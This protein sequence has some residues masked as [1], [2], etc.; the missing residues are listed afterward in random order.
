[1]RSKLI[2][3]L[4]IGSLIICGGRIFASHQYE[5]AKF[6]DIKVQIDKIVRQHHYV[7]QDVLLCFD[8]DCTL[9]TPNHYLGSVPWMNWQV[10]LL[11]KVTNTHIPR[12]LVAPDWDTLLLDWIVL[13]QLYHAPS[14]HATE[15]DIKS[16]LEDYTGQGYKTLILTARGPEFRYITE[17]QLKS[18]GLLG[19][20]EKHSFAF[21]NDGKHYLPY[22]TSDPEKY[23]LSTAEIKRFKLPKSPQYVSFSH[24]IM[25]IDGQNKGAILQTLVK[26]A[27][28]KYKYKCIVF[29]DDSSDNCSNVYNAFTEFTNVDVETFHYTYDDAWK[30]KFDDAQK[31]KCAKAWDK[32]RK[33]M[34][35]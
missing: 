9:I 19:L 4:I 6:A 26:R 31:K 33:A 5:A 8:N 29:V 14:V 7:P 11:G 25:L 10:G 23:G 24:G 35:N 34:P 30:A 28:D 15:S 18:I 12:D 3:S 22:D 17:E 13:Q 20:F 32:L 1:M 16:I 21:H 27:E 2:I